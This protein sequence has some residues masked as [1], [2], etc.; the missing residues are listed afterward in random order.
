MSLA[1]PPPIAT[2]TA[3]SHVALEVADLERSI[4][5]YREVLGLVVFQDDRADPR[6]PNVKGLVAGFGVELAQSPSAPVRGDRPPPP[7][8]SPCLSFAVTNLEAAF[9]TLKARGC[10]EQTAPTVFKGVRFFFFQDP[11]GQLIEL[12]E[13]PSPIRVLGDLARR[14]G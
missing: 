6:Q 7:A 14:I 5:F 11:D 1:G 13:F 10:V 8:P 2:V 3:L 4:A 9:E 12:I